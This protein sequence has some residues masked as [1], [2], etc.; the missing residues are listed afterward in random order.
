[1][2]PEY[3]VLR[4]L[5]SRQTAVFTEDFR[6]NTPFQLCRTVLSLGI[7]VPGLFPWFFPSSRGPSAPH[8]QSRLQELGNVGLPAYTAL[9]KAAQDG[10][11][12]LPLRLSILLPGGRM[13]SVGPELTVPSNSH[14]IRSLQMEIGLEQCRVWCPAM[15]SDPKSEKGEVKSDVTESEEDNKDDWE[16][17]DEQDDSEDER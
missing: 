5:D 14:M 13:V 4:L 9:R 3:T 7:A 16:E 1:M 2:D 12:M 10:Q 11:I 8:L 6:F 17:K 15:S